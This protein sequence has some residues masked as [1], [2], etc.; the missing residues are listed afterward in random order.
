LHTDHVGWNTRL[1]DGRWLPTF[2]NAR[3]LVARPE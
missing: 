2:P 3:Y 1:V